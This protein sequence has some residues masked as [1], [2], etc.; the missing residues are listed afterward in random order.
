[1]ENALGAFRGNEEKMAQGPTPGVRKSVVP[2][3]EGPGLGPEINEDG[4]KSHL[5]LD[6]KW[7]G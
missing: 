6:E 2:V 4:L 7:W 3:P 5:A 1:V